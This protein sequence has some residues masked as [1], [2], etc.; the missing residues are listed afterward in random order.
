METLSG[1]N[2]TKIGIGSYGIGGRGHRDMAI[3]EKQDD[4]IY[5]EALV[6]MFQKGINF[7]EVSLGY[8]HG[9]TLFLI[10]RAL[11]ESSIDRKDIF[12]THSLYPRDLPTVDTINQDIEDF[13]RI[14]S[15][16]YAD[17]TL[18]TQSLTIKFGK[19]IIYPLLHQLLEN[20]KTRYVSL[21]NASPDGIRA[22]K[23]EFGDK[24]FAHEGHL[25]FEVRALQDEGVFQ[26]CEDLGVENIIWRPIRRGK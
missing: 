14:M 20:G 13:Y 19:E 9:Q 17:S 10:K 11:D 21:S 24:F 1:K 3:T 18:V 26:T 22:Y 5:V 8:G 15:T 23:E 4:Q 16:D 25:S 6:Y 2:L 7:T 12:L